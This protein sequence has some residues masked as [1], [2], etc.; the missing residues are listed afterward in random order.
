MKLKANLH[1]HSGEDPQ[2]SIPYSLPE[3]IDEASRLH[4]DVLAITLHNAFGYSDEMAVYAA[5]KNILLIP[6]MEK[7]I[8]GRHVLILNCGIDAEG[9]TSFCALA[10]YRQ[11]HPECFIIAP[12]PYYWIFS[13]WEKLEQYEDCFDAIEWS[14]YYSQH[15]H[16]ANDRALAFAQKMNKPF[17]ATSDTHRLRYLD[18]SFAIIESES[19]DIKSVI[20][21][22]R[23]RVFENVSCPARLFREIL[24]DQIGIALRDEGM[25]VLAKLRRI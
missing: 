4:F 2:D 13:L 8:Q 21:A 18:R 3:G 7:T 22:L 17:I 14:W 1:F 16:G 5:Q 25:R 9:I 6:G 19:K 12:H 15:F 24:M 10:A 23:K 11:A 20:N